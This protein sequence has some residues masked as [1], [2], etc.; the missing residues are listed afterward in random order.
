MS[1]LEALWL[2]IAVAFMT[3]PPLARVFAPTLALILGRIV[4][5]RLH[6]L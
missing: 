6:L 5:R 1:F 3:L 4:L 2:R